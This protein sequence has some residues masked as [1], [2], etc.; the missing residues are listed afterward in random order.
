M[1]YMNNTKDKVNILI[2][3]TIQNVILSKNP[4]N[5]EKF[6]IKPM[7]WR[8]YCCKTVVVEVLFFVTFC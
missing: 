7:V 4:V 3:L 1:V 6:A 8:Y 5:T 2:G